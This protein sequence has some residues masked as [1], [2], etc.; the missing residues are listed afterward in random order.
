VE[1]RTYTI[2]TGNRDPGEVK[3]EDASLLGRLRAEIRPL[4]ASAPVGLEFII[5][6][7]IP[8]FGNVAPDA[9]SGLR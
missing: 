9:A 5:L 8:R 2:A 4:F 1:L 3:G 6:A 7:L